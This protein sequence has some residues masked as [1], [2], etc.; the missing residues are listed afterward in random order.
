MKKNHL[1]LISNI[2]L[3]SGIVLYIVIL[4]S[5]IILDSQNLDVYEFA[6][7]IKYRNIFL[8]IASLLVIFKLF[9]HTK[10]KNSK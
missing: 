9:L 5:A 6:K 1:K 7:Y 2:S 3:W 10:F 8:I 4:I